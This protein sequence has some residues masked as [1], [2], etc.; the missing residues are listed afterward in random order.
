MK[1]RYDLSVNEFPSRIIVDQIDP[2]NLVPGGT[3]TCIHDL[4]KYSP[5]G[6]PSIIGVTQDAKLKLGEWHTVQFGTRDVSFMPVARM[7]RTRKHGRVRLPDSLKL[8]IGVVYFRKRIPKIPVQAHRV[9]VGAVLLTA[10]RRRSLFQYIHNDAQGLTG[11]N[12]D[13]IWK[14]FTPLYR[15]LEN[16]VFKRAAT[17]VLFSKTDSARVLEIRPDAKVMQ[18]WYDSNLFHVNEIG[19]SR[20][21]EESVLMVARLENQKDPLLAMK[22]FARLKQSRPAATLTIL[23]S[24]SLQERM[25][26][27]ARDFGIEDAIQFLGN[28]PR[29]SVAANMRRATVL[30]LTSHYEGSP[31]VIAESCA[32]GLPVVATIGAD[33]DSVLDGQIN[34]IRVSSRDVDEL[35]DALATVFGW[36]RD[37]SGVA[38]TVKHRK[39]SSMVGQLLAHVGVP[40][41][42][43]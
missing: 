32:S 16:Y 1:E 43:G 29:E 33:T 41:S 26:E 2:C 42:Q 22:A 10:L 40:R 14:N 23:G 8:A 11:G 9:E 17:V 34:G 6:P 20:R 27:A 5:G 28:V 36:D 13:S 38:E 3:D 4:V 30:L 7:D 24:G 15:V 21:H 35:G 18:T 31:R 19:S 39:A 37:E 12:S 25:E